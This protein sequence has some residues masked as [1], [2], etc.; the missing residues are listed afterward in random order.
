M[1]TRLKYTWHAKYK[2]TDGYSKYVELTSSTR[3]EAIEEAH[4]LPLYAKL[5]EVYRRS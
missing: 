1:K 5:Y 3:E 2:R 4:K